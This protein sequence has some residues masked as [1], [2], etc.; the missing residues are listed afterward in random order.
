MLHDGEDD[1]GLYHDL[2]HYYAPE[3]YLLPDPNIDVEGA[4]GSASLRDRPLPV[5]PADIPHAQTSAGTTAAITSTRKS[6]VPALRRP[7]N[8]IQHHDAGPSEGPASVSEPETIE[9]PPAYTQIR[10]VQRLSGIVPTD[11]TAS[12]PTATESTTS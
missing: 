1:N 8:V 3:P 7:V 4:L 5:T 11:T 10:S 6:S 12:T 2:P 9:L